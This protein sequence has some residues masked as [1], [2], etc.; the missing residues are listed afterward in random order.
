VREFLTLRVQ[1]QGLPRADGEDLISQS[2]LALWRRRTDDD[3]AD[4][5]PRMVALARTVLKG[6]LADYYRHKLVVQARIKD[7]PN[8]RGEAHEAGESARDQ[9]NYVEEL[10]PRRSMTPEVL[11]QAK[12]QMQFVK[13]N[14]SK[15]GLTDADVETMQAV[16]C[17]EMTL[18]QAAAL[19][20]MKP[21]TL[22]SRLHRI[23]K[24]LN[25]AWRKHN[26]IRSPTTLMLLILLA[27]V[28]Y[29][30]AL[31]GARRNDPPPQPP[32]QRTLTPRQPRGEVPTNLVAPSDGS[33]TD[34][35]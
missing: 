21:S 22:R 28:I 12:Q 25:E 11:L 27:L 13:D 6:K 5:L 15:V 16:D 23:K 20:N 17:D 7:A 8:P 4:N 35:R 32:P 10:R 1:E 31:A 19:R 30:V 18:E 3:P 9:P 2:Y 33:K 14:A 34:P 26:L 29:A 24:R